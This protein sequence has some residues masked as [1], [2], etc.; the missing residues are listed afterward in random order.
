[1][2]N[3]DCLESAVRWP[4]GTLS[5]V[6]A[7]HF[8]GFACVGRR[9][10]SQLCVLFLVLKIQ[11]NMKCKMFSLRAILMKQTISLPKIQ[12]SPTLHDLELL[13]QTVQSDIDITVVLPFAVSGQVEYS[14]SSSF[15]FG[16]AATPKWYLFDGAEACGAILWTLTTSHL[17]LVRTRV[18][19]IVKNKGERA[20]LGP[21]GG[22][23]DLP[24]PAKFNM[25]AYKSCL[26]GVTEP[27][28]GLLNE[29]CLFWFLSLEYERFKRYKQ[30]FS[31]LFVSVHGD[32]GSPIEEIG[33]TINSSVR[34]TDTAFVYQT[35][36]ALL[37]PQA[38]TAEAVL[39]AARLVK[40]LERNTAP[41]LGQAIGVGIA[42]IPSHCDHPGVLVS[43]AERASVFARLNN[44]PFMLFGD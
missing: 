18:L 35:S 13:L 15:R 20:Q 10:M 9:K 43:A 26:A 1:M 28:S 16:S 6:F 36:F 39:C 31:L 34:T 29:G 12:G 37:L 17:E 8:C 22:R 25:E 4:T 2:T 5:R 7:G 44:K 33:R 23:R 38:D 30:P 19:E 32:C 14:L 21:I 11:V 3:R 41:G 24:P 42:N 27:T 40:L